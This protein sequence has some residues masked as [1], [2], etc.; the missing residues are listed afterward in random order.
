MELIIL[1][2]VVIVYQIVQNGRKKS[3]VGLVMM[4]TVLLL[5]H[6]H[7]LWRATATTAEVRI[8]VLVTKA[9]IGAVRL[10]ANGLTITALTAAMPACSAA[11]ELTATLCVALRTDTLISEAI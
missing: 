9:R 1:A 7:C 2:R 11:V 6:C 4:Q 10:M 8:V 3:Q 5:H